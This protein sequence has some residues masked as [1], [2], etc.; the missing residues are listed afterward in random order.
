MDSFKGTDYITIQPGDTNVPL[1]LKFKAATAATANDGS[2]PYLS[3][4]HSVSYAK[5]HR[6]GVSPT[7][8]MIVSKSLSSNM[9]KLYLTYTTALAAGLYDLTCRVVINLNGTTINMTRQYDLNRIYLK[10]R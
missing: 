2:I 7:S 8:A 1:W 9:V 6:E 4:L 3:T 5:V 10:D